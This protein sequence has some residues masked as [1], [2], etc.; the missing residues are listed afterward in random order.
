MGRSLISR[1]TPDEFLII[2][3]IQDNKNHQSVFPLD[4]L[5]NWIRLAHPRTDSSELRRRTQAL[6]D[7]ILFRRRSRVPE[8]TLRR[9]RLDWGD[10]FLKTKISTLI[11]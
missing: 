4:A 10:S 7:R 1:N 3:R 6:K 5:D 2:G 11:V 8:E 9:F